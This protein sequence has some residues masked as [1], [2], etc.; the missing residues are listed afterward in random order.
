MYEVKISGEV[1][2]VS[3]VLEAVGCGYSTWRPQP[4][5]VSQRGWH[6]A[7]VRQTSSVSHFIPAAQPCILPS[8]PLPLPLPPP[9]LRAPPHTG[10]QPQAWVS[11]DK[12]PLATDSDQTL[13]V[14]SEPV[15]RCYM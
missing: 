10:A 7:A 9:P 13:P 3:G 4:V 12:R 15:Q 5:L 8:L 1:R 11:T 14:L 2:A 6:R